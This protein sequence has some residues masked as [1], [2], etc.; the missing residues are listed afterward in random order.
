MLKASMCVIV[1]IHHIGAKDFGDG[2]VVR[3]GRVLELNYAFLD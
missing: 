3:I 2:M 1:V